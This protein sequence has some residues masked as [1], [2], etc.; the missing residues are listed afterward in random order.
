MPSTKRRHSKEEFAHGGDEIY[1]TSIR[2]HLKRA[3]EGKFVALDVDTGEYEIDE[4]ELSAC[5]GLRAR[6]PNAQIWLVR[7]GSRYVHRF[8]RRERRSASSSD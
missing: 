1:E 6:L 8:G 2:P 4:R 3:D 5:D 7:F